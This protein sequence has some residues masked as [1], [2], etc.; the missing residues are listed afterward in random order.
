MLQTRLSSAVSNL[1][2][3]DIQNDKII[4]KYIFSNKKKL[5]K[6]QISLSYMS[7]KPINSLAMIEL[8]ISKIKL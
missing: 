1:R 4:G 2:K 8:D 7:Q 3:L 5:T 6:K